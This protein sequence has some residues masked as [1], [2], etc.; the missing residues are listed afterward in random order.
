MHFDVQI[1]IVGENPL[2]DWPK[3]LKK[4]SV[5]DIA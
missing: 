1:P 4:N 3:I 5:Q 2:G